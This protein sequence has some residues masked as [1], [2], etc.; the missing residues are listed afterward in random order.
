M[1]QEKA[2]SIGR[3]A[4]LESVY[5]VGLED[6]DI[7]D[8]KDSRFSYVTQTDK[9]LDSHIRERLEQ[10]SYPVV[11]E[12]SDNQTSEDTYWIVDPIDGTIPFAYG[13]P[14]YVSMLSFVKGGLPVASVLYSPETEDIYSATKEVSRLNGSEILSSDTQTVHENAVFSSIRSDGKHRDNRYRSLHRDLTEDSIVFGVYCAGYGSLRIATGDAVA[15]LYVDLNEWD[16]MPTSLLVQSSGGVVGSLS[17]GEVGIESIIKEDGRMSCFASTK[18]V[19]EELSEM[20]QE[21]S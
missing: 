7:A 20:Y 21:T 1:E 4:I 11:T 12:E 15:A 5:D 13:L 18:E 16:Y 3:E 17:T 6:R 2:V 9:D 19:F 8:S 14:N 10:T